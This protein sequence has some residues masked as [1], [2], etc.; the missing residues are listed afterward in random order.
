MQRPLNLFLALVLLSGAAL[1]LPAQGTALLNAGYV[2]IAGGTCEA[3]QERVN[4]T[5][6]TARVGHT[7][8][9]TGSEMIVWGGVDASLSYL[10]DTF[11]YTPHCDAFRITSAVRNGGNLTL[12]F[13]TVMSCTYTLWSSDTLLAGSWT[14]TGLTTL[15]NG[16]DRTFT[17]PVTTP[18]R[19]FFRVQSSP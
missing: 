7:A 2:R 19:R 8:V 5:P 16:A 6:P 14:D 3:W 11:G 17:V 4:G 13:P 1:Q 10:N 12:G 15:G 9:W 18:A